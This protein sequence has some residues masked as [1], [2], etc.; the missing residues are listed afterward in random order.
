MD[1]KEEKEPPARTT[2]EEDEAAE[3]TSLTHRP[4]ARLAARVLDFDAKRV[5]SGCRVARRIS[6]AVLRHPRAQ[7]LSGARHKSFLPACDTGRREENGVDE[8]QG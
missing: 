3:E 7:S 8:R 6:F 2:R 5:L 4:I 1:F